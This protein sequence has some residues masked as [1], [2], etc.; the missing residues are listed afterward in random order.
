M[1][2]GTRILILTLA[3]TLGL[4]G[5]V[6]WVV[7]RD[8]TQHE[9]ERARSDIGRA[10]SDYFERIQALHEREVAPM[11]KVLMEEPASRAQLEALD[12][13][14]ESAQ[15]Q[16]RSYIFV[17]VVQKTLSDN[18]PGAAPME[19]AFHVILDYQ[20]D[21]I[22]SFSGEDP[23]LVEEMSREP[24]AWAYRPLFEE[25]PI[26]SRQYVSINGRLYL[27]LGMPLGLEV[28]EPPTHAYFI[29]YR[30]DD[31]WT[32]SLLGEMPAG[33]AGSRATTSLAAWFLAEGEVIAR[34]ATSGEAEGAAD[35]AVS[36]EVVST[37]AAAGSPGVRREVVFDV[38]GERFLGETVAFELPGDERGSLVVAS[39][40][41]QALFRLHQLQATIAWVTAG[42]VV[43]ALIAFRF[44]S[45]LI[46]RP[47]R[48][49]VD[50]TRRVAQ[51]RFD[52]PIVVDRRDELGEL[53]ASFNEMAVGLQQRD[54]VKS[55]FGKFVDPKIVEGFLAD[56]R[57]L[58][59]GGEKRVQSVLF[60]DLKG[61]SSLAEK[62]DADEL[63]ALLNGHLGAAAE[64][65]TETRGIV[66]KFIGDAVVAFWGPPITA[67]HEHAGLA[68]RAALRILAS[69]RSL[70]AECAR[71]G[72]P[73]LG[74][75]VGIATG[76]VVVGIIGSANKYSYTVM[77]D[78]ANLGSRLEGLN[79]FYDTSILVAARTAREAG[80]ELL[81][82]RID[83]VRVLGRAEP[84]E[85]HEVLAERA[86][87]AD[88]ALD[89]RCDAYAAA[90]RLYEA[91]KWASA[92]AEFER[93]VRTWPEDGPAR[94]MAA[95]CAT[96]ERSLP[97]PDWDGVWSVATK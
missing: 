72:V 67:D 54:L 10:V 91:R 71:L 15:E 13:G 57:R 17:E 97:A 86:Q 36:D 90:L 64:I 31:A 80:G 89:L 22:L 29:G 24:I 92:G 33:A 63:V 11:I 94:V 51:G 35:T 53:A 26:L 27:A 16:F 7:T 40:L 19:P 21:P 56:P 83:N 30:V 81:T 9:T 23:R 2:L 38:D 25:E 1:R 32:R 6:I 84:V 41:T 65:V 47:V 34:A 48:R 28:R 68:C 95:R 58:M 70:D 44:V 4:A 87:A 8:L 14:S 5:I 55:T 62:L 77:G 12:Q 75:R 59:P 69:T 20:G 45:N 49:L 52:Q 60:C 96:F 3:I 76:E 85:I 73:P 66:D 50:G 88:D 46:A 37:A 78:S 43:L 61:F 42:V 39:S 74:V 82:R 18:R 93:I 79:K